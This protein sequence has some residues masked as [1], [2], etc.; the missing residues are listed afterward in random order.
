MKALYKKYR[1]L[2]FTTISRPFLQQGNMT[3]V[4]NSD[5]LVLVF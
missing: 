4:M 5:N 2:E 1:A 3:I